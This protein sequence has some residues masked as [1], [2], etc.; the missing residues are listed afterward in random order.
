MLKLQ[1]PPLLTWVF[2]CSSVQRTHTKNR[3]TT[4]TQPQNS[5]EKPKDHLWMEGMDVQG[6]DKAESESSKADEQEQEQEHQ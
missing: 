4:K 3:T 6:E 5:S 1:L 2:L